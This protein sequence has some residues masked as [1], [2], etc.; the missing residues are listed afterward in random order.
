MP[1][2]VMHSTAASEA[3]LEYYGPDSS[4]PERTSLETFPFTIGRNESADL[5]VDSGRVSREHAVIT[6]ER[7]SFHVRD[8]N[9]TNGTFLNGKRIQQSRLADG[10]LLGIADVEFSFC[11]GREGPGRKTITQVMAT[12]RET[13]NEG[14]LDQTED[15]VCEVRRLHERLL[16]CAV[17]VAFAPIAGL[18]DET[19]L[20]YEVVAATG[21]ADGSSPLMQTECRL[22]SRI[23][24]VERLVAAE[25]AARLPAPTR[26][27]VPL[28]AADVD[29]PAAARSLEQL[30]AVLGD[31]RRLAVQIPDSAACDIPFFRDF[32]ALM[33]KLGVAVA[34]DGFA[35]GAAQLARQKDIAPDYVKLAPSLARGVS[36]NRNLRRSLREIVLAA[37]EV[38]AEVVAAGVDGS[39]S[40][41]VCRELGCRYAQGTFV[42]QPLPIDELPGVENVRRR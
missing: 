36:R 5:H 38:G 16:H 27:F 40:A 19:L 12:D 24:A 23:R 7:N 42:G 4:A 30:A 8:L 32:L 29:G 34:Y 18:V 15:A 10:D 37:E 26:V 31:P 25:Q 21:L 6:C 20:G 9:S 41:G 22:S 13:T 39:E 3:W 1:T 35:S 14:E 2:Q 17:E 28:G 11:C 33:R